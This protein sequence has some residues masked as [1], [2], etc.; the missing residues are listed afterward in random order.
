MLIHHFGMAS[1]SDF[2]DT[3]GLLYVLPSQL[4]FHEEPAQFAQLENRD[5]QIRAEILQIFPET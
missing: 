5:G 4:I 2:D 3:I 1:V